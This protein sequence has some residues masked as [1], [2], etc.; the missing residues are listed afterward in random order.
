MTTIAQM[1]NVLQSMA[2]TD[3]AK[4]IVTPTYHV[5][6]MYKVHQNAK[7][8]PTEIEHKNVY[9]YKNDKI[10][11]VNV[12]ASKSSKDSKVNVTLCNMDPHKKADIELVFEGFSPAGAN[13]WVLTAE[14][15]NAHNTF[16]EPETIKTIEFKDFKIKGDK[17]ELTMP[18]KSVVIISCN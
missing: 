4:M 9:Q 3:G 10:K 18:A 14:K 12:S 8:L 2:L 11:A 15:M 6:E 13:G 5:Y 16:K 7:L 17:I 1:I